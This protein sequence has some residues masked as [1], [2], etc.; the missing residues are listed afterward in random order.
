MRKQHAMARAF[1]GLRLYLI[2]RLQNKFTERQVA[3][4]RTINYF[5]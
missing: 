1:S 5:R 2:R 3:R 4:T